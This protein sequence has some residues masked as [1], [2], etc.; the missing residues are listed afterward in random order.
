MACYFL[1]FSNKSKTD[2]NFGT[3]LL[4]IV[5]VFFKLLLFISMNIEHYFDRA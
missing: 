5:I 4:M 1:Q 2:G 3:E